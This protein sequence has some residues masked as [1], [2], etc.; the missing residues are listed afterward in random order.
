MTD[1]VSDAFGALEN[2]K[3]VVFEEGATFAGG[4]KGSGVETVVIP[5]TVES[6]G[7]YGFCGC[8]NLRVFHFPKNLKSI[9]MYAFHHSG[10][11]SA[12]LPE[13]LETI[14]DE[15]FRNCG[16]LTSVSIPDTVNRMGVNMFVGCVKLQSVR[17]SANVS[18]LPSFYEDE[19]LRILDVPEGVTC[20]GAYALGRTQL[21]KLIL[22]RSLQKVDYYATRDCSTIPVF[23]RGSQEEWAAINIVDNNNDALLV[24]PNITFNYQD[25]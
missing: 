12:D 3:T 20:I 24:N 22:P 19:S 8:T 1:I 17:L 11:I 21:V 7:A 10:L 2:L 5:D 6:I 4:L 13:G 16:S 25:G 15:A 9:E 23:Y 18:E 14:G